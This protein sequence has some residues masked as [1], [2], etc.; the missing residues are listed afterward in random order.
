MKPES[1]KPTCAVKVVP[2]LVGKAPAA[3]CLNQ[4]QENQAR[5]HVVG[6]AP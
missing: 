5:L 6:E 3:K 1:T 4:K 2:Q